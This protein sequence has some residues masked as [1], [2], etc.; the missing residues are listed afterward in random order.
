MLRSPIFNVGKW[1]F[2]SNYIISYFTLVLCDVVYLCQ[3]EG[4]LECIY[5]GYFSLIIHSGFW[6]GSGGPAVE[7]TNLWI[8]YYTIVYT[9]SEQ[10][11]EWLLCT[12]FEWT[13]EH[14]LSKYI[15]IICHL[16]ST[17]AICH[18][19]KSS[20]TSAPSTPSVHLNSIIYFVNLFIF[21]LIM[22]LYCC[23][24]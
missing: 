20:T 15:N 6:D 14:R 21:M 5:I 1:R 24:S 22:P 18:L 13:P 4:S 12:M 9:I 19:Q 11:F 2:L 16:P 3:F 23:S 8:P 7:V 17:S 10:L